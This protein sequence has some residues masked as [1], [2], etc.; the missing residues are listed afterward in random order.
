MKE[1]RELAEKAKAYEGYFGRMNAQGWCY[2][3]ECYDTQGYIAAASPDVVLKLLDRIEALEKG[4]RRYVARDEAE[5]RSAEVENDTY[6]RGC[7][8][9]SAGKEP[10]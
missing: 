8:I 6:R 7:A 10:A 5:G 2:A 4:L 1:L 3:G 9:L